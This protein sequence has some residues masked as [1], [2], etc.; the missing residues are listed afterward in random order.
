M[1]K[2]TLRFVS[3]LTLTLAVLWLAS[4]V[5]AVQHGSSEGTAASGIGLSI[6]DASVWLGSMWSA[7][8]SLVGV[9][10]GGEEI[11][12]SSGDGSLTGTGGMDPVDGT[13]TNRGAGLDPHG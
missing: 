2:S 8:K 12:S 5:L 13:S 1:S 11:Y 6:T 3:A 9:G 4:P 10:G 7:V